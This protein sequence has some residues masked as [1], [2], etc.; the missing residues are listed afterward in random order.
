MI[1][2]D[3]IYYILTANSTESDGTIDEDALSSTSSDSL[4][5]DIALETTRDP[6]ELPYFVFRSFPHTNL[7]NNR[8]V[9]YI[10]EDGIERWC[11]QDETSGLFYI[12][13]KDKE[14]AE[15]WT[16][17]CE[18]VDEFGNLKLEQSMMIQNCCKKR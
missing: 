1:S 3:A 12:H 4:L 17:E 9:S 14:L 11:E 2:H 13:T 5:S 18:D 6:Y 10:G 8:V 15:Y 16:F 7:E